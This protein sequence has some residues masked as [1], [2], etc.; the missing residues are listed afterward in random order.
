VFDRLKVELKLGLEQERFKE[1]ELGANG[2]LDLG[3]RI[4]IRFV[5]T[6]S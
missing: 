1:D 6:L 2:A 3:L 5:E 4:G